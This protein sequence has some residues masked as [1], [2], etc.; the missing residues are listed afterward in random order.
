[1]HFIS[2]IFYKDAYQIGL[3]ITILTDA[4][5]F[6]PGTVSLFYHYCTHPSNLADR[7]QQ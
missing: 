2:L 4:Q 3:Y 1:M 7:S 6:S 5:S